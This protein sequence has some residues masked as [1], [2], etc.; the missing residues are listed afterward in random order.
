M[1]VLNVSPESFYPG[2]VHADLDDL[3]A[4]AARM[5]EGGAKLLDVGAM[6]TAPYRSTRI[7]EEEEAE[8]L[9]RALERAAE[10]LGVP[11]SAD[12]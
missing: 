8:R 11:I 7:A 3:L 10:K 9:G 2:S 1:G 5:V 4:S 6:S 12:T